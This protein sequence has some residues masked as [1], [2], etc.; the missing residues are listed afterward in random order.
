MV[1]RASFPELVAPNTR[2]VGMN[3]VAGGGDGG[4]GFGGGGDGGGGDG[5]GGGGDGGGENCALTT[6]KNIVKE[7]TA[8]QTHAV[9]APARAK[10]AVA[11][12]FRADAPP[13]G[14][15]IAEPSDLTPRHRPRARRE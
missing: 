3:P 12:A 6:P 2:T 5:G 8:S 13:P 7:T 1:T 4:G 15:R 10:P 14:V 11:R 9:T